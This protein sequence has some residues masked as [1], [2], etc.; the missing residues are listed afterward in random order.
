MALNPVERR[1]ALLCG[2]W[3]DF[4]S[5][6][7]KRLLVW[8]VPESALRLVQ[9]FFEVQ[10]HDLEYSSR[11][12]FMVFESPFERSIQYSRALKQELSGQYDA[13]REAMI[14]ENVPTDWSFDAAAV[15]DSPSGFISGACS[16]GSKYKKT[17]GHLAAVLQ[18]AK[19]ADEES[20]SAWVL[21]ALDLGFPE[22]L[23]FVIIRAST[24]SS[25][26]CRARLAHYGAATRG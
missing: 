22:R 16:F 7:T 2:E 19:I 8:Q 12:L 15:P 10:K 6:T 17:I 21:R 3:T 25:V 13:S 9:C 5:D 26:D 14:A 1:L 23:R 11:D 24:I 4:R 20:F 18:P